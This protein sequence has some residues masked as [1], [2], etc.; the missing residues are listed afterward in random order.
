[1]PEIRFTPIPTPQARALQAGGLD[2]HGQPPQRAVSDGMGNPCRHCLKMIPQSAAM[3]VLAHSPFGARQPYA[4]TGPVFLCADPCPPWQGADVP[5]VLRSSPDYML[6]GYDA[7]ERIVYGTGAVVPVA[8]L[9]A[10]A[11]R[12]LSEP[13]IAFVHIRS[14]RNG[15]F[16]CRVDRA[17]PA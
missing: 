11:G 1:M 8:E 3:L 15:C 16:Q 9:A 4:E 5:P 17:A 7:S 13:G 10:A 6:R 12:L 2:A 14:A